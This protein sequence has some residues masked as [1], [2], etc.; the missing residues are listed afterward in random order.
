[1]GS[2]STADLE[3]YGIKA[4]VQMLKS[5]NG[6]GAQENDVR[7]ILVISD[8]EGMQMAQVL[9]LPSEWFVMSSYDNYGS[10]KK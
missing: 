1:M 3:R 10:H 4:C 7:N 5:I 2:E 8:W 6:K 9:H